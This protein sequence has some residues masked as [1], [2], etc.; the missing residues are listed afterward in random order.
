MTLIEVIIAILIYGIVVSAAIGFAAKQNTAFHRGMDIMRSLQNGR[1]ALQAMENDLITLGTN[2]PAAQPGLVYAG[3]NV[4]AFN[5]DYASNVAN[6]VFASYVDVDAPT[7]QVTA[8]RSAITIPGSTFQYPDTVYTTTAGTASP[9]ETIIFA[10]EE[11]TTTSRTDDYALFRIVNS[12]A[13]ELVARY[14]LPASDGSPFLRYFQRKEFKSEAAR[15]DSIADSS[16]PL[17]HWAT[18]HGSPEDT[19]TSALTDSIRA[20]RVS[21]RASNGLEGSEERIVEVSRVITLPNA[22]FGVFATCGDEPILGTTLTGVAVSLSGGKR[23]VQLNWGAA[24]DESGG[25]SD[26]ARYVLYRQEVVITTDWGD[27]YLSIPAGQSTYQ[28]IDENVEIGKLYQ[29][30]LA[31][32]DCTPQL[33]QLTSSALITP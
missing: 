10:F 22:G 15:I 9:A 5:A 3:P 12:A 28:Y 7:G 8:L 27:P 16:L 19:S 24:T 13:P 29:Y 18:I 25:E 32:Q 1:Y 11:D 4:I 26:V 6:D 2:T 14:L 20:V 33:S 23:G 30:A 31:A 17:R 21:F